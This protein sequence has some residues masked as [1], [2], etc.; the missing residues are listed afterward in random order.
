VT[1]LY[2][3]AHRIHRERAES[4]TFL[5]EERLADGTRSF[6]LIAGAP[7]ATSFGEDLYDGIFGMQQA[8]RRRHE[9]SSPVRK[10]SAVR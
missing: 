5:R 9:H 4:T 1:H 2:E 8:M 10:V 7:L 6:K 3:F